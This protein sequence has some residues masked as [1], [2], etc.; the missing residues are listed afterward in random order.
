MRL[1]SHRR[2]LV[3]WSSSVGPVSRYG[4][5]RLTRVARTRRIRRCIRTGGLLT[6]IGLI[7]L[8]RAVRSRWRPLLVGGALTVVSVML[9][10]GAS[11]AGFLPGA[12]FLVVALLAPASPKAACKARSEL[13]RE[14]AACSTPA[15]RRDL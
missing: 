2:N 6:V 4:V 3:V 10:G 7:R 12:W 13:E 15:Q 14:L 1:R 9:R 11:S 5:P 8:A